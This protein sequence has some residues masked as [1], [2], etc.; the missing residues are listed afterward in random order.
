ME[1]VA[2]PSYS[3]ATKNYCLLMKPG[4]IMGNIVTTAGGFAL[5]SKG[6][7]DF[8]LFIATLVGLA[9]IIGSACVF[10]N[11]IDRDADKKME[12]TKDRGLATGLISPQGAILFG[13]CLGLIG[14]LVLYTFT[15]L[16]TVTIALVGFFVYVIL[17]SFS[18]Y[19]SIHGTLIG[20][21]AGAIPPVVGYCAVSNRVD[22]GALILFV[23]MVMWQMP[24]FFAIAIYRLDDYV[25]AAIPI[26]PVKKGLYQTKIH[27]I[28]YIVAFM[29]ASLM[30]TVFHYTNNLYFVV[31]ALL[32]VSWLWLGI[33]GFKCK[34][35]RV[36]ARQMFVYSLVVVM[37][38]YI[39]IPFSVYS[40]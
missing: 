25:Q 28:L 26:L 3:F 36:W 15:N 35:D 14:A 8:R 19:Y 33:T 29:A 21:V 1:K 4:I 17:Y 2:I 10:N 23:M 9:L 13:V 39:T 32:G 24:H 34:D 37:T 16:I 5:A 30:L 12:R 18:K 38:L 7:F 11:Y 6:T 31:A 40:S 22:M 27:M 20:S